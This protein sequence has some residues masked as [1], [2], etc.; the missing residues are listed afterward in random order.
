MCW[1]NSSY[2]RRE[3][4]NFKKEAWDKKH[5][6]ESELYRTGRF[7]RPDRSWMTDEHRKHSLNLL[8][9]I[10]KA[11]E[12]EKY[13]EVILHSQKARL[14]LNMLDLFDEWLNIMLEK[15][16]SICPICGEDLHNGH[17]CGERWQKILRNRAG[18]S[19]IIN[20]KVT[21]N[22][23]SHTP[24][25]FLVAHKIGNMFEMNINI[26]YSD[27]GDIETYLEWQEVTT[28]EEELISHIEKM[29]ELIELNFEF[30]RIGGEVK[31]Q[32][33]DKN[34]IFVCHRDFLG[35]VERGVTYLCRKEFQI[36]TSNNMPVFVVIPICNISKFENCKKELELLRQKQLKDLVG[37]INKI[38]SPGITKV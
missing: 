33:R 24:I 8:N 31:L 36:G 22:V 3:K 23:S 37:E 2:K 4:M 14:F 1:L 11:Y 18:N 20:I 19:S 10:E 34:Q 15:E 21:E 6:V 32:T 38:F 12:N 5:S 35:D 25:I 26:E 30:Y 29:S 16:Y 9:Q 7:Q 17:C 13:L 28:K 27:G